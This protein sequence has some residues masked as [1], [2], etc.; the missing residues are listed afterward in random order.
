MNNFKYL[1]ARELGAI[2]DLKKKLEKYK[3]IQLKLFGSK[4]RGNFDKESDLDIF[5]ILE[6]SSWKTE[7]EIYNICFEIG[8]EY[9]VVLSPLIYSL[10]DL[11]KK[12]IAITPFYKTVEK[13]GIAI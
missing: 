1:Q 9:D 5:I 2:S 10:K 7:K 8:L 12:P 4:A 13:E 3:P 11:E 6:N